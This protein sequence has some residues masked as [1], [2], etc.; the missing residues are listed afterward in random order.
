MLVAGTV[1]VIVSLVLFSQIREQLLS[2]KEQAAIDQ[3]QT[4]VVYAQTEVAGI[5]AG[6]GASVRATLDRTVKQLKERG[7]PAGDFEVVMV[8]R[9]GDSERPP[10]VSQRGIYPAIPA[11][12]RADVASGGQYSQYTMVP[13]GSGQPRPTYL[14]GA[15]VPT[16]A[17]SA[18]QIE[19]YYAFP[20]DQEAESLS[21]FRSTVVISGIA[22]T[23]FVVGIRSEERRVGKECRSR[24]SPYH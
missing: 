16:G 24:W 23:L 9:T 2:V 21:L 20:L 1:V 5:A 15:P 8:Y 18:E 3:V 7:S 12:L 22:L 10:A 14:V 4:G 19:L 11:E 17:G 6:D 13:D